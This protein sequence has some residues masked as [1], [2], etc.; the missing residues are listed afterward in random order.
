MGAMPT[1]S[2][3]PSRRLSSVA[4]CGV[5]AVGSAYAFR[6]HA[7]DPSLLTVVASGERRQRLQREGLTVNGTRFEVRCVGPEDEAP[8]AELV[9]AAVK[10]HHLE[11]AIADLKTV[12]GERTILISL[13]N[14]VTSERILGDAFGAEKVLPAY[15]VASDMLRDGGQTRFTQIGQL[16]FGALSKDPGDARVLAVKELLERAAIPTVI[17]TDILRDQ[18]WKFMLNVGVNQVSAMLR[19]P[20]GAFSVPHVQALVRRAAHEVIAICE[21]EGVSL[22]P[23]DIERIFPILAG[24]SP[25]GK[26]SMLQD[27]EAGRKTEVESFAGAVSEMGR[28][29]GVPTPVNDLLGEMIRAMEAISRR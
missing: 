17:S 22:G 6:L 1:P 15:V 24:L 10:Q 21:R 25:Q 23:E 13:L 18:W 7:L 20:Y 29:H 5:G 8:P 3:P 16:V 9:F 4:I 12:V 2:R 27:V 19:A 14:G 11:A 26:T 28:R